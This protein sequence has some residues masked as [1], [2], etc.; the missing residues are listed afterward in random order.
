MNRRRMLYVHWLR[1]LK[2]GDDVIVTGNMV[3]ISPIYRLADKVCLIEKKAL[4]AICSV[5]R[6]GD[7]AIRIAGHYFNLETGITSASHSKYRLQI[8]PLFEI[9]ASAVPELISSTRQ[10]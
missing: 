4:G 2:V 5:E 1:N 3:L 9:V 7:Q 10:G 6:I 8:F